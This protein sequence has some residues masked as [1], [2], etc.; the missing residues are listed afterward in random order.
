M[1]AIK[2]KITR[3]LALSQSPEE[4]EAKAALL[5][6][7]ELM[8]KHKLQ[9]EDFPKEQKKKVVMARDGVT[10]T[11]MTD[12]WAMSMAQIVGERYCCEAYKSKVPKA[13]RAD[14]CFAGFED[15]FEVCKRIYL[16]AYS[17]VQSKCLRIRK[18]NQRWHRVGEIR[19]MCNAYGWGFCSGL[20]AAF[21]EQDQAHQ[22]WG[23]V[24]AVPQAV[25]DV[26][27]KM[28]KSRP[29]KAQVGGWLA[30]YARAGYAE[31]KKYN[32]TRQLGAASGQNKASA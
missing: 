8:A 31:G 4:E 27:A 32:P 3:L 1:S 5:K 23:L 16:Y 28:T 7:R 24:M 6:A 20:S 18:G 12:P 17:F 30:Q 22:E 13:K 9:P 25:R 14:V 11:A 21:K 29:V 19:Q 2:D 10:Y 15:D 26:T